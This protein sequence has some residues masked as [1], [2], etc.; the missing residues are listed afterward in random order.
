MQKFR[1][2]KQDSRLVIE[3]NIHVPNSV[4]S[5]D[6]AQF[7]SLQIPTFLAALVLY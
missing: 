5:Y 4:A 3:N 6:E 1:I 7:A 2:T